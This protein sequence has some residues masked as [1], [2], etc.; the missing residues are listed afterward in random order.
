MVDGGLADVEVLSRSVLP[1]S[2]YDEHRRPV[3][4]AT[5]ILLRVDGCHFLVTAGHAVIR[6]RERHLYAGFPDIALQRVPALVRQASRIDFL[7]EDDLDIGLLPLPSSK[8]G[9]FSSGTFLDMDSL[10]VSGPPDPWGDKSPDFLVYGFPVAASQVKIDR[11]AKFIRQT[12]FNLRTYA[13]PAS[14]YAKQRMTP[15]RHLLLNHDPKDVLVEGQ[16]RTMPNMVG[17]SGGAVIYCPRNRRPALI[18][19]VIEHH[20]TSRVI[21]AT[22]IGHIIAFARHMIAA[23]DPTSFL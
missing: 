16:L 17:V 11:A 12:S 7:V 8:L 3:P 4:Q 9:K 1:L 22:R 20:R 18:A 19:M 13:S 21:V 2:I 5:G 14:E 10:Y 23:S 15:Q 6:T